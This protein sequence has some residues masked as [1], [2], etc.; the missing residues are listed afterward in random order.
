MRK[1]AV[2]VAVLALAL[3]GCSNDSSPA[4]PSAPAPKTGSADIN[5]KSRDELKPGGTLQLSIQQWIT[6]YNVGQADGTQGDGKSI[7]WM[8]EPRLWH[9]D[10]H[11]VPSI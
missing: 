9:F 5:P 8:V 4:A 10:D 3:S 2:I 7:V 11:G 6:Q 1:A